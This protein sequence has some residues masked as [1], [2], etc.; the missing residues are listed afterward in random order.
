MAI[1]SIQLTENIHRFGITRNEW[2]I[3]LTITMGLLGVLACRRNPPAPKARSNPGR[4][5]IVSRGVMAAGAIGWAVWMAENGGPLLAGVAA[6]FPAI[7]VTTMCGLWL[8]HGESVGAGAVGPL[9]L[10][11][12]SVSA[13][14]WMAAWWVPAMGI[15]PAS[16][17]AWVLS[18]VVITVPAWWWLNTQR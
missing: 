14:A 17:F 15:V 1:L 13:Y 8:A 5:A 2:A 10:G 11:G 16:V 3:A 9:M 6:V 18:V 12:T 7:F 4:I